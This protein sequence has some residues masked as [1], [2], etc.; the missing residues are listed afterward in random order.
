MESYD[1]VMASLERRPMDRVPMR[2]NARQEVIAELKTYLG[3]DSDD[4]LL[5][6]LG[7]DFRYVAPR[8]AGP[9]PRPGF[10]P[11]NAP[12]RPE[13]QSAVSTSGIQN[14]FR[15]YAPFANMRNVSELDAY[16]A[17]LNQDFEYQ[18]PGGMAEQ[19]DRI[20]DPERYF[21]GHKS[22]GRIF[23]AAQELRGGEQFLIDMALNP[24]FAHRLFEIRTVHTI[25]LLEKVLD[26]VGDRIDVVQYNDDLGTQLDL[27]I[28]PDMFREFLLP[29]YRRIFATVHRYGIRVF[30]H[31]CGAIRSAIPDLIDAGMNILNPI[32]VGATGMAPEGLKR[33]FGDHL[34]FCGG[35]DV[36]STLPFG[37][38][39]DVRQEVLDRI[40][41]LG[42]DGGYILDSTNFIQ[43]DTSP[44]NVM[45]MF[46][47]GREAV[48][49]CQ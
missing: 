47:T 17:F 41:I 4:A 16:E 27:M 10:L 11:E 9:R 5:K 28:S 25:R 7:I 36:Q 39:E 13:K 14:N 15:V 34:T 35:I 19:I 24:E 48:V 45:A 31:C 1:R 18:D 49:G 43:P 3:I 12:Q 30:M 23:M 8:Y 37:T 2:L 29:R 22:A 42:K 40:E 44:E 33:D 6:R 38:P 32:Q 46:D 20:N 26:E 21:V